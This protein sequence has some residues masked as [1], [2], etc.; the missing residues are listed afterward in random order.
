MKG[1]DLP[2][3]ME[4]ENLSFPNPWNLGAF[5]GELDNFPISKAYMIIHKLQKKSIGYIIYWRIK[6][7]VQISNFAVH[8]DFRRLGIGEAVFRGVIEQ[9]RKYDAKIIILEVR[10]TNPSA[11]SLYRK[12]GF[13]IL[14]MK[15][16]YYRNPVEDALL[17]GL[18][19]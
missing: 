15:E 1:K 19:L 16:K 5:Q 2:K 14:G 13:N 11:I 6:E 17:M 4:I 8:P 9:V 18:V 3:V 7:E 10:P 12:L